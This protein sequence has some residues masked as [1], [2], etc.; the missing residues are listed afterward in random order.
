MELMLERQEP[1]GG[2]DLDTGEFKPYKNT[3]GPIDS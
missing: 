2:Y 3:D 1:K